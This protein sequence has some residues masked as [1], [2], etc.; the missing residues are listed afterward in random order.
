MYR[1]GTM[2]TWMATL[3]SVSWAVSS[4]SIYNINLNLLTTTTWQPRQP[5]TD[6]TCLA[7]FPPATAHQHQHHKHQRLRQHQHQQQQQRQ[8]QAISSINISRGGGSSSSS[9][10]LRSTG[11]GGGSSTSSSTNTSTSLRGSR[12]IYDKGQGME[13]GEARDATTLGIFLFRILSIYFILLT[14]LYIDC[15]YSPLLSLH[16]RTTTGGSRHVW[17]VSSPGKFF[18]HY[19]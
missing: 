10:S 16:P 17:R 2:K 9:N 13:M 19:Y 14:F 8:H 5:T 11:S 6:N 1:T 12:R 4:I 18:F 7:T 15:A 3:A